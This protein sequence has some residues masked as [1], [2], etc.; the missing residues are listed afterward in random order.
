METFFNPVTIYFLTI[1]GIPAIISCALALWCE[2]DIYITGSY[3]D[4]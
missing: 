4:E 3:W 2:R 1:I